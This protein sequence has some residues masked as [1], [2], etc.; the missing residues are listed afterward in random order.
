MD[1]RR[2]QGFAASGQFDRLNKADVLVNPPDI[3]WRHARSTIRALQHAAADKRGNAVASEPDTAHYTYAECSRRLRRKVTTLWRRDIYPR[4]RNG[5]VRGG[6]AGSTRSIRHMPASGREAEARAR[7]FAS[8]R[9]RHGK[10]KDPPKHPFQLSL[11]S[12]AAVAPSLQAAPTPFQDPRGPQAASPGSAVRLRS[13]K[14]RARARVVSSQA[15]AGPRT[16][17]GAEEAKALKITNRGQAALPARKQQ[18]V[19][20]RPSRKWQTAAGITKP[21]SLPPHLS[22]STRQKQARASETLQ[23]RNTAY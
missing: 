13:W 15:P 10:K 11:I 4:R 8:T 9:P 2:T 5:S 3:S 17:S 7:T 19:K 21:L 16:C 14:P 6:A 22:F 18:N 23:K 12:R 1:I 20:S